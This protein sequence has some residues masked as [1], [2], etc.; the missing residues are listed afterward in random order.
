MTKAYFER[1]VSAARGTDSLAAD[2]MRHL[3]ARQHLGKAIIIGS[4]PIVMLSACRK[5]WLKLS[6]TVQRQRAATLNAD[7]ILK[8]THNITRMQR[9]DFTYKT[10]LTHPEADVYCLSPEQ[11]DVLPARCLSIY[12]TTDMD[13][14]TARVVIDQLDQDALIIDYR[15]VLPWEDLQLEPKS[16]LEKQVSIEWKQVHTFL[17]S[18]DINPNNLNGG[19]VRNVDVMDDALDTLL[20]TS[21][22]FLEVAN[23]FH[24]ALELARPLRINKNIR[25]QYDSLALLAHRVQALS[26]SAFTQRFLET[27]NEDDTFFLYDIAKGRQSGRESL[28]ELVIRHRQAK[29]YALADAIIAHY[30]NSWRYPGL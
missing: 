18:R 24:R 19:E 2:V 7:K 23:S 12:L 15:H 21:Q 16:V 3:H 11:T 27:Y 25:L 29:R 1:R 20:N 26:P 9:M 10:A 8:Y 14:K 4:Q 5:Q 22:K 17:M 28:E 6:R 13:E 30:S